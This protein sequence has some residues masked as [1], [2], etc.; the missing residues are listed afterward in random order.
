MRKWHSVL[1]LA[2]LTFFVRVGSVCP[3]ERGAPW[4]RHAI[5]DSSRGADGVRL[6]DINGDGLM[7]IT[8]PWEEGGR[9]RVYLNPGL[10]GSKAK[11]PAVTVGEVGSPE[12]AVF[13]DLDGD[14]AVDV[15]SCCEGKVKTMWAHWSPSDTAKRL[16][17][18]S[19]KTEPIPEC[20]AA[21]PAAVARV[22]RPRR[23]LD[24]PAAAGKMPAVQP[25]KGAKSWM[26]CVPM[27]IDGKNGIDLVAGAK[28]RDAEIGWLQSPPNP[29][30]LAGWRWHPLC[31]AGWIMSLFAVDMDGDGYLDVLASD[32]KG[33]ARGCFW[34]ENPR[35]VA[36]QTL[37]WK[38]HPIGGEDRAV[39]FIVPADLDQDG[40][41]DVLAA[42]AG[43]ELVYWRRKSTDG[44]AWESFTIQLPPTAGTGKGV[45]V[46]DID[47]DG[48]PDIIFSCEHAS[49]KSGVMW[50]SY[51]D[52]ATDPLWNA[53]EI[54]GPQGVKYDLVQL[55]D[56]D[57]DGDPDVL[58]CEEQSNLGVVWYENPTS[59]SSSAR[60]P[61]SS[62]DDAD[63]QQLIK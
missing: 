1:L 33:P 2:A 24:A 56:L 63:P 54:S 29:R 23:G 27:Q 13:V 55:L 38:R 47:M 16:R 12:D 5:D 9:V 62:F 10:S 50:M 39:M 43:H 19:W 8:T 35:P 20:N 7:D 46:G 31:D 59:R 60:R 41:P 42:T 14:G 58:T 49:G 11:W 15:V 4:R 17:P 61:A 44:L 53:H 34:L 57:G 48:K 21:V 30:D 36:E 3:A 40:L 22:S 25:A 18:G 26:F 45:S 51:R 6:A 28:G 32:R 52:A 37:P